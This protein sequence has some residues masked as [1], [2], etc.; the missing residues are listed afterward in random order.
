MTHGRA[1]IF[2]VHFWK[3][4]YNG[5][6]RRDTIIDSAEE[7]NRAQI[8]RSGG[9]KS[10]HAH[11]YVEIYIAIFILIIAV[12]DTF[13]YTKRVY[14]S[15][16]FCIWYR[17]APPLFAYIRQNLSFAFA[18]RCAKYAMHTLQDQGGEEGRER[19]I[20]ETRKAT[21]ELSATAASQ[22]V[23]TLIRAYIDIY[24]GLCQNGDK[25]LLDAV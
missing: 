13:L 16:Y 5:R 1:S 20:L 18:S 12:R 11:I 3:I 23:G 25:I 7:N 22:P 21:A 19:E 8:C 24:S 14:Y 6:R 15:R 9:K 10:A 2:Q 17:C 4:N